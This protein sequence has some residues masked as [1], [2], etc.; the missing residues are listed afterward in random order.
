MKGK[1]LSGK[2]AFDLGIGGLK[3]GF[4]GMFFENRENKLKRE[5]GHYEKGG[6]VVDTCFTPDTGFYETGIEEPRYNNGAWVIVDEYKTKKES[7][8]GHKK[9]VALFQKQFPKELF[10]VHSKKTLKSS[11]RESE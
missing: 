3:S 2:D 4:S 8:A 10:D 6:L 9:W 7:M 5:T 1:N 11:G